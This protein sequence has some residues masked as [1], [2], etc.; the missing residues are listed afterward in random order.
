M[1]SGPEARSAAGDAATAAAV[2]FEVVPDRVLVASLM[3][4]GAQL[5]QNVFAPITNAPPSSLP[6]LQ[7]KVVALA[8]RLVRVF[9]EDAQAFAPA[10][11]A[12]LDSFLRTVE[13]A[14]TAGA[15]INVTWAGGNLSTTAAWQAAMS[16]FADVL[17][18]LVTTRGVRNLSWVTLQNE[19]NTVGLRYVTPQLLEAMY[20]YLDARLVAKGLRT[21]GGGSDQQVRFMGGDLI[22]TNQETW[23]AYMAEHMAD[24]LDAY[25]VHIYW[26]YDD[27]AKIGLRLEGVERIVAALAADARKPLVVTEY[28][29][30]GKGKPPP[31]LGPSGGP[32]G[33]TTLAAF[34]HAW[35]QIAAVQH[36][37]AGIVKWDCFWGQYD[38]QPQAFYAVGPPAG[39]EWPRYPTYEVLWLLAHAV[40]TGWR[41]LGVERK[42]AAAGTKELAVFAGEG[43][44][45]TVLGLDT[46]GA[47][48][49]RPSP[50]PPVTYAIGGLP[51]GTS[52]DLVL[53][54]RD[55]EGKLTRGGAVVVDADGVAVLSVPLQAVFALT[56]AVIPTL[57]S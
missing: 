49:E 25:S 56:T 23:F 21:V 33:Q 5:N 35:F 42:G 12:T 41:A 18:E 53:W 43:G 2:D 38:K 14:Q 48:L 9:F 26:D 19:P 32:I 11:D 34:Q 47:T 31:G 46:G 24:I 30:R 8:P 28:G 45:L 1:A 10:P 17:G 55:G 16:R 20:R 39:D 27:T 50:E 40:P 36:G 13:L 6:D 44:R 15:T 4:S 54:N 37:F 22:Q 52:L 29:V 51:A 7:A 3:G 57:P